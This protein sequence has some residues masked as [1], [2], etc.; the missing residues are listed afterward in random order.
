VSTLEQLLRFRLQKE[1]RTI[2]SIDRPMQEVVFQ[3][4]DTAEREG[5]TPELIAAAHQ[6]NPGNEQLRRFC[7]QHLP[8]ALSWHEA[9]ESY[10]REVAR[11]YFYI[12]FKGIEQLE[13]WVSLPL[14]D[15]FV[16]LKVRR[17][18]RGRS[19]RRGPRTN[20][21]GRSK[22]HFPRKETTLRKVC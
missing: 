11:Q 6:V 20:C 9:E 15:V 7:E 3:L 14:D 19:L 17:E 5:W 8:T 1:L 16:N 22:L 2:V 12:D 18:D 21:G 13:K 10:L 4:V